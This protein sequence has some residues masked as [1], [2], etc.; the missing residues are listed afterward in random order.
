MNA[1]RQ[2][3]QGFQDEDIV[4]TEVTTSDARQGFVS[5]LVQRGCLEYESWS[6]RRAEHGC[7]HLSG[8]N[9]RLEFPTDE[10][11]RM[12]TTLIK[13][14]AGLEI[15]D[16]FGKTPLLDNISITGDFGLEVVDSL[17]KAGANIH[18]VDANGKGVFHLTLQECW[19]R[20]DDLEKRL[21]LLMERSFAFDLSQANN[22]GYTPSDFALTPALWPIWCKVAN[23]K[24]PLETLLVRDYI[25]KTD[26]QEQISRPDRAQNHKVVSERGLASPQVGRPAPISSISHAP[27][28]DRY[29][30]KT[31]HQ[32]SC[33]IAS[34][35]FI[36]WEAQDTPGQ[37]LPGILRCFA[38]GGYILPNDMEARK[39][40]AVV[41]L[42]FNPNI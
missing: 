10:L 41:I 35:Q 34:I 9:E 26:Y 16:I 13:C 21:Q 37:Q 19:T 5:E 42:S 22:Q 24:I 36:S 7:L 27:G 4:V 38:Y 20:K 25:S 15:R 6:E 1:L 3:F 17:L 14:G 2:L 12:V 39:R 28:R 18:A 32:C 11:S 30:A 31:N 29:P 8:F 40:K 23:T 33:N